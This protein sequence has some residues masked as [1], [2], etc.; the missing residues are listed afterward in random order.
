MRGAGRKQNGN[1]RVFLEKVYDDISAFFF[2]FQSTD[3]YA[4]DLRA[5]D[6]VKPF[7]P[8][9]VFGAAAADKSSF[10]RRYDRTVA[11]AGGRLCRQNGI[12]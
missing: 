1:F 8:E 4:A 2:Y 12:R 7:L 3:I 10:S 9:Q 11:A 6:A 5:I